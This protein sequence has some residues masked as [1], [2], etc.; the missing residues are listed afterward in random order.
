VKSLPSLGAWIETWGGQ[1]PIIQSLSRS[2]HWERG[3]KPRRGHGQA[4][5]HCRSLHW[6]RGLKHVTDNLGL[7]VEYESLPSLGAWIETYLCQWTRTAFW[8]LPSL[9]AWIETYPAYDPT[10]YSVVAPFTGSVD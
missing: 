3:L 1:S 10:E 4:T 6:E 9:G 8:S 7:S 2:L 5:T